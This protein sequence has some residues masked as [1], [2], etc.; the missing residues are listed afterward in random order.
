M[1]SNAAD[2]AEAI[3]K[4]GFKKWYER[5]LVESHAYL[6]TCFLCMI[7]VAAVLEEFS[8]RAP[9]AKPLVAL[10]LMAGGGLVGLFSWR[11]YRAIMGEAERLGDRSTCEGCG[12]YAKFDVLESGG[13]AGPSQVGDGTPTTWLRVRCRKC[14]RGWTMP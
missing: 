7:L 14:G 1:I 5:K 12:A 2:P 13:S 8:F 9:G 10:A 4:L 11:R 6:V 3:R